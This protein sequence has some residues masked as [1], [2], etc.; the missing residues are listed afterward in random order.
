MQRTWQSR[1]H[2]HPLHL[3]LCFACTGHLVAVSAALHFR[4]Q[5]LLM[6]VKPCCLAF[7]TLHLGCA[8]LPGMLMLLANECEVVGSAAVLRHT[9]IGFGLKAFPSDRLYFQH[10]AR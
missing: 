1:L 9:R 7:P 3:Q 5:A 10:V 8:R 4:R 6:L 2:V